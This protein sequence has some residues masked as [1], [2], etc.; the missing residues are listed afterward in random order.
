MGRDVISAKLDIIFK[1]IFSLDENEDLLHDFLASLLEI[2]YN[3]IK[4]IE[5][6][7]SDVLPETAEGKFS[8]MDLKLLVDDRLVN[9]EMQIRA[10]PDFNDRVLYYW[11]KM[12]S[13]DLRSGEDYSE[14]KQSI[15]INIINFNMFDCAEFHSDFKL[16]ETNRHAVLSDKCS[17]QLFE[18]KKINRA[19]NKNNRMELWLQL[20]NAE[21]EE[22][23]AMLQETNVPA[24]QK[25]VMVIHKMSADE[26]MQEIARMREK[27]LHDEASALK[28]ARD[29]GEQIGIRKGE[30][31]KEAEII[32]KMKAAGMT[33]EQIKSILQ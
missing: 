31:K 16:L 10:Q 8:R 4:K 32:S 14:L 33:D 9:V 26:K 19:V 25:A 29:E 3:D 13:G 12:Y 6:R 5:V 2:P 27:A 15:S 23:L 17:I 21:S 20:I 30:T 22:E 11:S 7:N 1:K 28:G 24:I 18:L